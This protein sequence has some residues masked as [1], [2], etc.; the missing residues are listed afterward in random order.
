VPKWC[1][2]ARNCLIEIDHKSNTHI[3]GLLY[4]LNIAQE[5]NKKL[6]A[7][8]ACGFVFASSLVATLGK[9]GLMNNQVGR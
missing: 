4:I 6:F 5:D 1:G 3:Q 2:L 7:I 9:V 8:L